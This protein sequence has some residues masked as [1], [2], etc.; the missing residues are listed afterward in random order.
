MGSLGPRWLYHTFL[1]LECPPL[2]GVLFLRLYTLVLFLFGETV[3]ASQ[4]FICGV[5]LRVPT[6]YVLVENL[7]VL[8]HR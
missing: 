6:L 1:A 8:L 5:L 4:V 7:A 2:R 3:A